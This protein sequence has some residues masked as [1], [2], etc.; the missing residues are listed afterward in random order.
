MRI[1]VNGEPVE[2]PEG[3]RLQD[4]SARHAGSVQ[5]DLV[6]ILNGYQT[7]DN[8][9]LHE[10]DQVVLVPRGVYP[11]SG[12]LRAMLAARNTPELTDRLARARVG[13]AGLG[14]L[15]SHVATALA[16][17]GVGCLHLVDFDIVEPSNLNRQVYRLAQLGLPKTEALRR[18]IA[19]IAPYCKV[20]TDQVRIDAGNAHR[21]FAGDDIVCEALDDATAKAMLT[22]VVLSTLPHT[23]LV[24]A[25]GMAGYASGNALTTRKITRRF[26]LCGDGESEAGYGV[27]LMAPRVMLCAG[28]QA[29]TIL[30]LIAGETEP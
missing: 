18:E 8:P 25:S 20:I 27:G 22:D 28:H 6:R 9:V 24:A 11:P 2:M 21:L 12:E 26:Y 19:D 10:N 17:T 13:I 7:A 5:A 29:L 4:L 30:R 15:G 16:R 1:R 14:G 23:P 3:T